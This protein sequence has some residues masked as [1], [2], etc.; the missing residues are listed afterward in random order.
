MTADMTFAQKVWT[1]TARI[2]RGQVTT[3]GEVARQLH[4]KAYQ[5][6]GAALWRN[7]YAPRVPCHRVVGSDGQLVGFAGGIPE[8][9][10]MLTQEGIEI[11][12]GRV[13]VERYTCDLTR[14]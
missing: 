10:R 9:Q 13:D 7:P 4:S 14:P 1:V 8:K 12:N 6:V 3:Y 2:P 5:A 11:I